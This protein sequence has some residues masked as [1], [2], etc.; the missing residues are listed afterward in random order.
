MVTMRRKRGKRGCGRAD[1]GDGGSVAVEAAK[2][3]PF[4]W[5][6]VALGP[7]KPFR[8]SISRLT[9]IDSWRFSLLAVSGRRRVTPETSQPEERTADGVASQSVRVLGRPPF[10]ASGHLTCS[11]QNTGRVLVTVRKEVHYSTFA[12]IL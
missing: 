1:D 6:K 11:P 10:S 7:F 3:K 5:Q 8:A 4:F 9:A 2:G 12:G